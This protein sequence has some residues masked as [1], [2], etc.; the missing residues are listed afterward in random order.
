MIGRS[1]TALDEY[2]HD[3]LCQGTSTALSDGEGAVCLDDCQYDDNDVC[4]E[5]RDS[6][7]EEHWREILQ[8]I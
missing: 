7:A 8:K 5:R 3:P 4:Q 1:L 6:R 2:T